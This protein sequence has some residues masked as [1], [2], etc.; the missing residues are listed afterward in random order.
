[1]TSDS[2]PLDP[3]RG[4]DLFAAGCTQPAHG[5]VRSRRLLPAASP[6]P[7]EA[8]SRDV[9][10]SASPRRRTAVDRV[11][12]RG[13]GCRGRRVARRC[14]SVRAAE[15]RQCS[16]SSRSRASRTSWRRTDTGSFLLGGGGAALAERLV[17][18][19]ADTDSADRSAAAPASGELGAARALQPAAHRRHRADAWRPRRGRRWSGFF[20][21]PCRSTPVP[22][23]TATWS[24]TPASA[25]RPATTGASAAS[26]RSAAYASGLIADRGAAPRLAM[27]RASRTRDA[28]R[29]RGPV[30]SARRGSRPTDSSRCEALGDVPPRLDDELRRA[31]RPSGSA[32]LGGRPLPMV[33]ATRRRSAVPDGGIARLGGELAD[34]LQRQ[35]ALCER[36][37][38]RRSAAPCA[39][40]ALDRSIAGTAGCGG[41]AADAD[42]HVRQR[43]TCR[44]FPRSA[45]RECAALYR[46]LGRSTRR[47]AGAARR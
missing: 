38:S 42:V 33:H 47:H 8:P 3:R 36:R 39:D 46:D 9:S 22:T 18:A 30:R 20:F 12:S 21:G 41:R 16:R 32:R 11:A 1:M 25:V 6:A 15:I 28:G 26:I 27:T 31:Y 40:Q 17:A 44:G 34:G 14:N 4:L 5:V 37:A 43:G 2:L 24:C 35:C 19:C 7:R 23:E 13:D 10:R 45:G 29:A